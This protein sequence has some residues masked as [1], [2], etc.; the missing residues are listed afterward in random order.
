MYLERE[1][2]ERIVVS[3]KFA[4]FGLYEE[5]T[6]A[7]FQAARKILQD[8]R[9][10]KLTHQRFNLLSQ[11]EQRRVLIARALMSEPDLLILDEP[12]SGLDILSRE[13]VVD[14]LAI[15]APKTTILYVTHHIDELVPEIT[16][17]LLL[18][19]GKVVAQG[20]KEEVLTAE[21]LSTI[22]ELPVTVSW[23]NKRPFLQVQNE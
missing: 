23:T 19:H 20:P 13:Q 22:Y 9:L 10:E 8:L 15:V 14:L 2:V 11:G 1:S 21:Q 18:H 17:C 6:D 12:C 4:S 3:G 5:T 16:H 7:D